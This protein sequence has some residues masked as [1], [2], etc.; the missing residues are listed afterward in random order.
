MP[1]GTPA[2]GNLRVLAN[3]DDGRPRW[4]F[5]PVVVPITEDFIM[6]PDGTFIDE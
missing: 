2:P 4:R 1:F 5:L 6:T 3:I